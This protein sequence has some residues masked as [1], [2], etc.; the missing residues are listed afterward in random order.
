MAEK[1][2][3][4]YDGK[5]MIAR[6][7][8]RYPG[9][10]SVAENRCAQVSFE[11]N[12]EQL[13]KEEPWLSSE[14]LVVKP[15]QLIKRRGNNDLLLL[16]ASWSEAKAW[17]A[18]RMGKAVSLD[19]ISG[20]INNFIVEPFVPH[21]V[22]VEYYFA[23][24]SVREGD[25]ILFFRQGGVDVGDIDAKADKLL[26]PVSKSIDD[27]DL[28]G[29]ILANIRLVPKPILANFIKAIYK[30]YLDAGFTYLEVN[31]VAYADGK[32]H[33]LDLAAKLDDT[34]EFEVGKLWGELVFPAPFGRRSI[35]E[36]RYIARLDAQSGASLKFTLLNKLGRVWTMVAGGGA[37]VIYTDTIADLGFGEEVAN[38]GE[39]SG[40][41]NEEETYQY[42]KTLLELMTAENDPKN[43]GKVLLI[44]GGIANFTDVAKT[45]KG[46]IRALREYSGELKRVGT[47][48]FVRR[49]G[50]N[51][52]EGLENMKKLGKEI[53]VPIEVYGPETHMT[54]IV[55]MALKA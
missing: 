15:D 47:K 10:E 54:R 45:F 26:V 2:I 20:E 18:E 11:S 28:E 6:H 24:R 40:N 55:S 17:I 51:Y 29:S 13:L 23:I 3:R 46:I 22:E 53:G 44:G 43:R 37:S 50:P 42:A 7:L 35:K 16:N 52:Q 49:G 4:E 41:P 27:F 48:I 32:M 1:A 30:F 14:K 12:L 9:S 39:Y 33:L 19:G 25:E 34:A 36:E 31:P 5:R 8:S 21:D 38:Y